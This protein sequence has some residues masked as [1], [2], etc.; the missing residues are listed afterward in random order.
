MRLEAL[1]GKNQTVVYINS[2][3]VW[4]SSP[5]KILSQKPWPVIPWKQPSSLQIIGVAESRSMRMRNGTPTNKSQWEL[6]ALSC[7]MSLR[8]WLWG[9]HLGR[10]EV[11][12]SAFHGSGLAHVFDRRRAPTSTKGSQKH[13]D[14]AIGRGVHKKPTKSPFK[15]A[16]R[17][18]TL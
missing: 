8:I 10:K 15:L 3:V 16:K 7:Y 5:S 2:C 1:L 11:L 18:K 12:F 9:K 17:E 4:R 6:V 14:N 13:P